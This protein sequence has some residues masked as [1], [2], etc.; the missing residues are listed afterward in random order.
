MKLKKSMNHNHC[1]FFMLRTPL[2]PYNRLDDLLALYAIFENDLKSIGEINEY[3]GRRNGLARCLLDLAKEPVIKEALWVASPGLVERF[4]SYSLAQRAS[5]NEGMV[6]TLYKYLV[7]MASRCTPFGLFASCSYGKISGLNQ[8]ESSAPTAI[9][10]A[11]R[12]D[13]EY[14]FRLVSAINGE[15]ALRIALAYRANTSIY[16]IGD[17]LR[18]VETQ[19]V[20]KGQGIKYKL[21]AV[22]VTDYLIATLEYAATPILPTT[23]AE[24]LT[25]FE[26]GVALEEAFDYVHE[27]IDNQLLVPEMTPAVTGGSSLHRII[28]ALKNAPAA[29]EVLGMLEHIDK[30]IADIDSFGLGVDIDRYKSVITELQRLPAKVEEQHLFQVDVHTK[31]DIFI[32]ERL[33]ADVLIGVDLLAKI[34]RPLANDPLGDFKRQFSERYEEQEIPL[35]EALDDDAGIGFG[36]SANNAHLMEPLLHGIDFLNADNGRRTAS[37]DHFDAI[38][39]GRIQE[40]THDQ[41]EELELDSDLIRQLGIGKRKPLPDAVAAF[42]SLL[43]RGLGGQQP[44][45]FLQSVEG[46][47]GANLM[48]RFC[49]LDSDLEAAVMS[50]LAAEDQLKPDAVCAEIA[51][52]PEGRIGNVLRRPVLRHHEIVYLCES[53]LPTQSRIGVQ[54]LLISVKRGQVIL[55]SRRIGKQVIPRL[56]SAHNFWRSDNLTIYQFLCLVQQQGINNALFWSWGALD[57]FNFLPRVSYK[58]MILF[59]ASWKLQVHDL[60]AMAAEKGVVQYKVVQKIRQRLRLPEKIIIKEGDNSILFSLVCPLSVEIFC[61]HLARYKKDVRVFEFLPEKFGTP[62]K[63]DG[64]SHCNEV[65]IPLVRSR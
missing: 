54:D 45:F 11:T 64:G 49:H 56:T 59:P 47:G 33:V 57:I 21:S 23:L 41:C 7:R 65:I 10:R 18:Y 39:A 62:V 8:L 46:P 40:L 25:K 6:V 61:S 14:I 42:V 58:H 50:C 60:K 4:D 27:L 55:R 15:R 12:L 51:H 43:G 13:M 52:M 1:G 34:S 29:S 44:R 24:Y 22:D 37:L 48:G 3:S 16:R 63:I 35:C 38:L 19:E 36:G 5:F 17:K 31:L 26:S 30:S 28:D 2:L 53:P 20:S 32:S 9:G